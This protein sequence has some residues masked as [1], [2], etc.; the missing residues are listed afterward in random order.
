[1]SKNKLKYPLEQVLEI[2]NRRVDEAEKVVKEK[3]EILKKEKEKLKG[4]QEAYQKIVDHHKDKLDQLRAALDEGTPMNKVEQMRLYIK[5]VKERKYE[6]KRKVERQEKQVEKAEKAVEEAQKV[7]KERRL[8][9]DKLTTHKNDW[10]KN[11]LKELGRL[12][13]KRLEEV[14]SLVFLSNRRKEKIDELKKTKKK[15][16]DRR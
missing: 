1:M 2:K 4:Y 16:N 10:T 12:E 6:E 5:E 3:Q 11:E 8:E 14:G 9:V 7:L 15:D 13:S